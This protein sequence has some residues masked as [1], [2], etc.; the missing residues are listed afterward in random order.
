[1]AIQALNDLARRYEALRPVALL[2][3]KELVVIGTLATKA[4]GQKLLAK[5]NQLTTASTRTAFPLAL[6]SRPGYAE[7]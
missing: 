2:H 1:M 6:Q 3:I 7:R 4:R 5:L